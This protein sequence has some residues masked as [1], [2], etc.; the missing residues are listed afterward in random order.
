MATR[1]SVLA[2]SIPWTEEPHG[3]QS[4]GSYK[5]GCDRNSSTHG[6][7]EAPDTLSVSLGD[8]HNPV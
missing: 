8:A 2:W 6:L 5:V 3:L 1:S 7:I 4:I